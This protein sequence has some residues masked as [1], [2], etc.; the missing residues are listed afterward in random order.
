MN[1][2]QSFRNDGHYGMAWYG[3]F[4]A[5]GKV[6]KITCCTANMAVVVRFLDV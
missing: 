3:I 1:I 6:W 5:E 2:N 4:E